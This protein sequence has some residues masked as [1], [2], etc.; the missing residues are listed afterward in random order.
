MGTCQ[1]YTPHRCFRNKRGRSFQSENRSI[2]RSTR[3]ERGKVPQ[4]GTP[5]VRRA[6]GPPLDK[7]RAHDPG[8][9]ARGGG[10]VS[11]DPE[12]RGR[13][14]RSREVMKG[15][16]RAVRAAESAGGGVHLTLREFGVS[17][18]RARVGE[19][20]RSLGRAHL[21]AIQDGPASRQHGLASRLVGV[22]AHHGRCFRVTHVQRVECTCP[23]VAPLPRHSLGGGTYMAAVLL[24]R[25]R[26]R[27]RETD[28]EI[29]VLLPKE[30]DLC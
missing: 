26:E 27:A 16:G 30:R 4:D 21:G 14:P 22:P 9:C 18:G 7:V 5:P 10:S 19:G 25:E 17:L 28:R 13:G 24:V 11:H 20:G 8:G 29:P 1:S 15:G 23:L 2:F 12:A 6:E 3:P